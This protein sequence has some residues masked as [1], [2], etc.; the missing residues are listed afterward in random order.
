MRIEGFAP[1][2][3]ADA[4]VLILGTLPGGVSLKLGEYYAQPQNAFWQIMEELFGTARNI[5]YEIR[6]GGLKD[7]GIALWDVCASG[8][9]AGSL[10]SKIERSSVEFNKFEP[11]LLAHPCIELICFNGKKAEQLWKRM[12]SSP[13]PP[14]RSEVLPSSS[15][16]LAL[17]LKEKLLRWRVIADGWVGSGVAERGSN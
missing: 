14:I 3:R 10:D 11:F 1:V 9:R 15:A 4:R 6:I 7:R 8:M 5:P 2:S 16:A 17:P 13:S 12:P